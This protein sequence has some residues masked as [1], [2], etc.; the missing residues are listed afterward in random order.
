[1]PLAKNIE[2]H[3][4]IAVTM[5]GLSIFHTVCHFFN[6]WQ[7]PKYTVARFAKWGWGGTTFVTGALILVA[8]FF[9]FTAASDA[10]KRAQFEVFWFAHHFFGL[11]Y[12]MLLLHGPVF[13]MWSLVPIALYAYERRR[14]VTRGASPFLVSRVE[15]GRR[16]SPHLSGLCVGLWSNSRASA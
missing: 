16:R 5:C 1:M 15:R 11:Y 14:R 9:I 7:S 3:K 8:M 6:Y 2:C 4:L 12:V 13:Y 10:V